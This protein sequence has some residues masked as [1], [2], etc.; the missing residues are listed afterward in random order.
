MILLIKKLILLF[1]CE[2]C[3]NEKIRNKEKLLAC[4]TDHYAPFPMGQTKAAYTNKRKWI[5][6]TLLLGVRASHRHQQL[7]DALQ[8]A[9]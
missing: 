3:Q 1:F 2:K 9:Q 5:P 6:T 7:S 4:P 8:D